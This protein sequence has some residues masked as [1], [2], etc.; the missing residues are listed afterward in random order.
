MVLTPGTESAMAP[1]MGVGSVGGRP[2]RRREVGNPER[3]TGAGIGRNHWAAPRITTSTTA[4][5]AIAR[6]KVRCA[7]S[8]TNAWSAS[9]GSAGRVGPQRLQAP[10]GLLGA[11]ASSYGISAGPPALLVGHDP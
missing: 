9:G 5:L 11:P 8:R 4:I 2:G 10:F 1:V 3:K 7:R 6:R